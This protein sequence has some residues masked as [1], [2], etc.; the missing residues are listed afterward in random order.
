MKLYFQVGNTYCRIWVLPVWN[1]YVLNYHNTPILWTFSYLNSFC[2]F[3]ICVFIW[4][5][6]WTWIVINIIFSK[7]YAWY[8]AP[9]NNQ[10]LSKLW[11]YNYITLSVPF[12]FYMNLLSSE[13]NV[14][15]HVLPISN[16]C[17]LKGI[18]ILF[19]LNHIYSKHWSIIQLC[20]KFPVFLLS[21]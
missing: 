8:K 21:Y 20:V 5:V 10:F 18:L 3:W 16:F 1:G 6:F 11:F 7:Y 13:S 19:K 15:K 17:V 2:P 9:E 14:L 12:T 4:Q